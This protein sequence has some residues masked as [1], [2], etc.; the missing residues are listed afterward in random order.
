MTVDLLYLPG[1]PHHAEASRLVREVLRKEGVKA[2]FT[3]S[4]ISN[5]EEA[6]KRRFP[7]SPTLRV[8]GRDIEDPCGAQGTVGFACRTYWVD[9]K[10]QGIP[11]RAWLERAIRTAQ[12]QMEGP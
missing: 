12:L 2:H 5:L 7:G 8:N 9:G 11:P 6:R 4:R 1:C 10:P 3:E